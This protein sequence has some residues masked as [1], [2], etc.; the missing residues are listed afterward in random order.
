MD[1]LFIQPQIHIF[2]PH[3]PPTQVENEAQKR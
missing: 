3:S 1:S 2:L